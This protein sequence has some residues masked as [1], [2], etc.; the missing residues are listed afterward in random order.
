MNADEYLDLMI[1][2]AEQG[3]IQ[4]PND[5]QEVATCL[6]AAEALTRFREITVPPEFAQRLET[7]VRIRA[8]EVLQQN[9]HIA[10][11]ASPQSTAGTLRS[12][13]PYPVRRRMKLSALAIAAVLVLTCVGVLTNAVNSL[14][15]DLLNRMKLIEYPSSLTVTSGTKDRVEIAIGQ[16]QNSLV[17]LNTVVS[18]GHDD[19][20][21][22]IAL[23]VVASDTI[24]SQQAVSALPTGPARNEAQHNLANALADEQQALMLL[25]HHL[26]WP[27]QL[28]FTH[29]LGVLGTPVPIITNTQVVLQTNGSFLITLI[30]AHFS[31]PAEFIFDGQPGGVVRQVTST[32]MIAV[33]NH[34][35]WS[36]DSHDLGILNSDGTAAQTVYH[37]SNGGSRTGGQRSS[38][39]HRSGG[40]D[41]GYDE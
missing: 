4:L 12:Q 38:G 9:E 7:R 10:V 24:S 41:G 26:D 28:A 21:I 6:I 27:M 32:Q 17:D 2:Q 5:N 3:K 14:P 31:S 30:G 34:A 19:T 22:S 39:G 16:L 13:A 20:T 11:L 29:Q 25:M 36:T 40:S 18:E 15:G 33:I 23:N 1:R 35:V 37:S 8:H